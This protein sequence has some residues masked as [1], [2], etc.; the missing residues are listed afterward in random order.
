[1]LWAAS[2]FWWCSP[3]FPGKPDN[4][5]FYLSIKLPC[6]AVTFFLPL[7]SVIGLR[8]N[9][10]TEQVIPWKVIPALHR[11]LSC[12][13]FSFWSQIFPGS[14]WH[15]LLFHLLS[16]KI[17]LLWT[18]QEQLHWPGKRQPIPSLPLER[19]TLNFWCL[20]PATKSQL[21]GKLWS[22]A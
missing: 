20:P 10:C 4:R 9:N 5:Y 21:F 17:I 14:F 2:N 8:A 22:V 13:R 7:W 6:A 15:F 12:S 16:A 18:W 19:L 3:A 11:D 1:M